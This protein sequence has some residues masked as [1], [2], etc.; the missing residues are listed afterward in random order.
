[1]KD[2]PLK[3]KMSKVRFLYCLSSA[4]DAPGSIGPKLKRGGAAVEVP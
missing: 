3:S 4:L 2:W 1:M